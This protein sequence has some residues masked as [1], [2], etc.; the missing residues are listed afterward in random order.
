[1]EIVQFLTYG[2]LSVADSYVYW[3]IRYVKLLG[4]CMQ[5]TAAV[6]NSNRVTLH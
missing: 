2:H 6:V 3:L 4:D 5:S 1:M